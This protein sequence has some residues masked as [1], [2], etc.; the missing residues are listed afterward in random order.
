[1]GKYYLLTMFFLKKTFTIWTKKQKKPSNIVIDPKYSVYI[2]LIKIDEFY[3]LYIVLKL[4]ISEV[5]LLL[6]DFN[7]INLP[8]ALSECANFGFHDT[9]NK[10]IL[11]ISNNKNFIMLY[12]LIIYLHIRE[13]RFY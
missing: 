7:L 9:H 6:K 5:L 11:S 12:K 3:A 1:M 10:Y 13:K 8:P 2:M 4:N